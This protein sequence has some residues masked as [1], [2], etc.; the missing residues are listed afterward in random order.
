MRNRQPSVYILASARHGTIYIGVTSDLMAR[1][2][3]HRNGV[4]AGF[5][6]RYGVKRLVYFEMFDDMPSAIAREKQLQA[7]RRDWKI[8]LIER[9]NPFWEDRAIGLGFDPLI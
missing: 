4:F 1:L 9:D 8:A 5:S 2:Y 7:W 3:Q 6:K